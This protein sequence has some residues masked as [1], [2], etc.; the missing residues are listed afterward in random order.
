[1]IMVKTITLHM[2]M[3]GDRVLHIPLPPDVPNGPLEVVL[4][5][6]PTAAPPPARSLAGRW[7]AHFPSDFDVD[8]ALR[9]I[10]HDWEKEW[11]ANE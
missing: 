3:P 9:E 1:M 7:Q 2:D 6:A 8:M 10:R 4:V 11:L 5:I